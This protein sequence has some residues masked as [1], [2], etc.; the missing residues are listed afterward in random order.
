MKVLV[1]GGAGF[2]GSHIVRKLLGEGCEVAVI[3]NLVTGSEDKVPSR[4][5]IYKVDVASSELEEVMAFEKPDAVIHQAAQIDVQLSL[6]DPVCDAHTNILGTVNVLNQCRKAGVKKLVYASSAAAYGHP[7]YL[8]IDEKHPT[9]PVSFYGISKSAPEHYI[10]TFSE[11]YGLKH[12]ILRYSNVYGVGQ[13]PKGEGGVISIFMDRMLRGER[14]VIYGDGEQTRDFVY[15]DDVAEANVLALRNGE[16]VTCNISTNRQTSINEL[17]DML[18]LIAGTNLEPIYQEE[19]QG[20]IRHSRLDNA[21]A[22]RE[23]KWKPRTSLIR[24]LKE[25]YE[26]YASRHKTAL[27]MH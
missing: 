5:P 8:A 25:T 17:V 4:C 14:P 9:R 20:D 2:I 13:D 22:A 23:L 10:R 7:S 15:V 19:R 6:R 18:N 11:L 27:V 26:Y 12:V 16:N 3:D 24:G 1:T 21:A